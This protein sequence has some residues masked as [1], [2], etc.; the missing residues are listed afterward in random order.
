MQR[1]ISFKLKKTKKTGKK[2]LTELVKDS[3]QYSGLNHSHITDKKEYIEHFSTAAHTNII[4]KYFI[5]KGQIDLI[6]S[7][8]TLKDWNW[9]HVG[10]AYRKHFS[11][12]S[13][14]LNVRNIPFSISY[15]KLDE[16]VIEK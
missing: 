4:I 15:K 12:L 10:K 8:D 2:E 9:A 14:Y 1:P 11:S 5:K 6:Q 13:T 3:F 16:K 7:K